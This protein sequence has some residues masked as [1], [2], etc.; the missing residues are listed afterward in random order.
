MLQSVRCANA[1][2]KGFS[3][4]HTDVR[5]QSRQSWDE[6][7]PETGG[8]I[9]YLSTPGVRAAPPPCVSLLRSCVCA[10]G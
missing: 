5:V 3:L 7:S 10:G 6:G 4:L 8:R 2:C 1:V 9:S